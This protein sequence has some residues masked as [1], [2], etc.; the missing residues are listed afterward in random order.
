L[1]REIVQI[2]KDLPKDWLPMIEVDQGGDRV[3]VFPLSPNDSEYKMVSARF[4]EHGGVP[5]A[6]IKQVIRNQNSNQHRL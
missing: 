3:V 4:D 2:Q 5:G 6:K 1:K